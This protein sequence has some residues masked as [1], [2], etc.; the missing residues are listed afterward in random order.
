MKAPVDLTT[1]VLRY[2]LDPGEPGVLRSA[3]PSRS[4]PAVTS[5]EL[6]NLRQFSREAAERGDQVVLTK[7]EYKTAL[8]DG[9]LSI[10]A[11]RTTVYSVPSEQAAEA[12]YIRDNSS[13]AR[14][15]ENL[16]CDYVYVDD[17]LQFKNPPDGSTMPAAASSIDD[18]TKAFVQGNLNDARKN[19]APMGGP[20]SPPINDLSTPE[21]RRRQTVRLESERVLIEGRLE[22]MRE[23]LESARA[24]RDEGK[25][26]SESI[27]GIEGRESLLSKRLEDVNRDIARMEAAKIFES[28]ARLSEVA[29]ENSDAQISA[30]NNV[31]SVSNVA[32]AFTTV[33]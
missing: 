32:G 10:K 31:S 16:H 15:T 20:Q 27:K 18:E 28:N 21:G 17:T 11:G 12:R 25:R 5:Q 33:I 13:Q 19:N 29:K 6:G 30:A 3:T 9:K 24:A 14:Y 26:P 2:K 1:T 8:I 7:I 4:I 22:H 23:K